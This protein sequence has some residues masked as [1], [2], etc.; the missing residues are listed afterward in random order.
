MQ[1]RSTFRSRMEHRLAKPENIFTIEHCKK[2]NVK[3][4]MLSFLVVLLIIGRL[5]YLQIIRG[6]VL[7]K[8]AM[9]QI[10]GEYTEISPRGSIV[11]RNGEELA[12]SIISNPCT[13]IRKAWMI[14][15]N[16]GLVVNCPIVTLEM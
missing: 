11:D 3:I 12:V 13:L 6:N 15:P 16:T 7:A 4:F 8:E 1:D 5:F 10:M 2:R 9:E 14:L